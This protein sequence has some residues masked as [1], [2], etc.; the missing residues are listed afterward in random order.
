M[1]GL[2]ILCCQTQAFAEG[3]P[4][5]ALAVHGRA[6]KMFDIVTDRCA[7]ADLPDVNARAFRAADGSIAMFALQFEARALRGP[8]LGRLKIDCRLAL[9]SHEDADPAKYD[10]RRYITSTWTN[11]GLHVAALIHDEYHADIH[12][13]RCK[14]ADPLGCWWNTILSFRSEDGG[15]SFTPSAPLVVAATPFTQDVEQGRHRG[16]FNPSNMFFKDG[17]VY[18]FTSTT[19]WTGQKPGACLIR[20]ANPLDSAGWRGWDGHAF[21]VRWSDPYTSST[22]RQQAAC[23]PVEPFGFPVGAVVR[24]RPSGQFLALWEAP[25]V[26]GKFAT[27]GFYYA[28]SKDLLHWSAPTLL[29]ATAISHAPCGDNGAN[30]DGWI[31]TYPSLLDDKAEGRNFDNV[32][33]EAWL[34]Y[35][36]IKNVGCNPAG[37]RILMRQRVSI[38]PNGK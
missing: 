32:G 3:R 38:K 11:D 12:P 26:P 37:Q 4:S 8:D 18:A 20:N 5:F 35:A 9:G 31:N 21:D 29:V 17:Y 16:F 33:D 22:G 10:G 27:T 30:S 6:E 24:H 2:T 36:R 28:T 1:C 14:V 15:K 7:E 23:A 13:G 19:G 34:Y 25:R